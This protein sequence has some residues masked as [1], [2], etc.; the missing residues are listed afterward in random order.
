ML[1][2]FVDVVLNVFIL[3]KTKKACVCMKPREGQRDG[4]KGPQAGSMLSAQ[5]PTWGNE[6]LSPSQESDI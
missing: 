2:F 1:V 4:E 6:D 5:S 3:R